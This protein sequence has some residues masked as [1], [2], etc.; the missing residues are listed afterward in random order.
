MTGYYIYIS[1][2]GQAGDQGFKVNLD[3]EKLPMLSK[4]VN[5]L[6]TLLSLDY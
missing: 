4:K 2:L 5:L 3:F 1:Y 6:I